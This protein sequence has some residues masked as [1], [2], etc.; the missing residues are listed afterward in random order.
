MGYDVCCAEGDVGGYFLVA[1]IGKSGKDGLAWCQWLAAEKGVACVPLVVF[2]EGRSSDVPFECS[3]VR[4]A[5]CKP[6]E[7]IE[8]ACQKLTA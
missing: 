1:D 8:L 4:F 7:T 2:Y 3:L 6:R 5:I